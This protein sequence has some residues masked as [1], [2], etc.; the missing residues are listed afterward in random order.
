MFCYV[1]FIASTCQN[2]LTFSFWIFLTVLLRAFELCN[3]CVEIRRLTRTDSTHTCTQSTVRNTN[4]HLF[5]CRMAFWYECGAVAVRR[6]DGTIGIDCKWYIFRTEANHTKVYALLNYWIEFHWMLSS[7]FFH[8]WITRVVYLSLSLSLPLSLLM[9]MRLKRKMVQNLWG[10]GLK[11]TVCP[12]N[13]SQ[14]YIC[15]L[16]IT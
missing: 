9:R 5:E 6:E 3:L 7:S 8:I 10:V 16:F 12:D 15:S 11:L 2:C 1:P 14:T 13:K 4:K